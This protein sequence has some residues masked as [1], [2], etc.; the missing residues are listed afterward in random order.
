[1]T[2]YN[3]KK[4]RKIYMNQL[5]ETLS[6]ALGFDITEDKLDFTEHHVCHALSP[7]YFYGLYQSSKPTLVFTL[8]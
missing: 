7:I 5:L 4:N 1:M 3:I 6:S 8:D 2:D